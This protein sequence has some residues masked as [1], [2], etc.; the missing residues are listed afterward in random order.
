MRASPNAS[1][2]SNDQSTASADHFGLAQAEAERRLR[3]D[4]YNELPAAS[5]RPFLKIVVDVFLQP[6]FALLIAGGVL[7]AV[8]GDLLE[9]A[10]LG[11]FASLSVLITVTQEMRSERVLEALRDLTSPRALVLRDGVAKRIPGREVAVGDLLLLAEGDRI[12]ADA[13]LDERETLLV[14]ES[15]LTGESLA[16]EK[17]DGS[18]EQAIVHAGTL[19]TRGSARA[20]VIATGRNSEIGKIGQSL[21]LIEMEQPRLQK[22]M[23]AIVRVFGVI[24]AAVTILFILID[25]LLRHRWS[26]AMLGGIALG[27]SMLPEEFPLVMTV[28]TVMGAWRISRVQVLTRKAS[29]IEA[30]GSATVLCT[31]KTGTL[32]QNR[33]SVVSVMAKGRELT[34]SDGEPDEMV[35]ELL[36]VAARASKRDSSDAV[37]L[38]FANYSSPETPIVHFGVSPEWPLMVNIYAREGGKYEIDAKGAPEAIGRLCGM[39]SSALADLHRSLAYPAAKGYRMLAVAESQN[40]SELPR[41]IPELRL[42]FVGLAG[43]ADPLRPEARQAVEECRSAGIRV[44]MVT[45]DYPVT[46]LSVAKEAGI[47]GGLVLSGAELKEMSDEEL[48]ENLTSVNVFARI[49]PDQKLRIVN[50][51]KDRGEVVAMTGDGVNDAPSLKAAHIGIA[52]GGRGTD[53]AREAS[54]IV[55]L[56]DDFASLVRTIK[57]GRRIYDNLRKAVVFIVA[58]H[59]PIAGLTLA[60]FAFGLPLIMTP[61]LIALIEMLIDPACSLVLEAEPEETDVMKR[62]PHDPKVNIVTRPLMLWGVLQGVLALGVVVGVMAAAAWFGLPVNEI[63]SLSFVLL[64]MCNIALILSNRSFS[65]SILRAFRDPNPVLGWGT[66]GI[67]GFFALLLYWP[68][69]AALFGFGPFHGHDLAMCLTGGFALLMLLVALKHFMRREL[70]A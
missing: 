15:L 50:L 42:N 45:G 67:S 57:L 41:S 69:A 54:S 55:L 23:T 56:N 64:L 61:M 3:S 37:D 34:P 28:F 36:R 32:T 10:V 60:P 63:R 25:G 53:V 21:N 6:M 20:V 59:I 12:P 52:M 29:A 58:V 22:Q 2:T 11:V 24:G 51:L 16:V 62:P 17:R 9:A 14:D 49:T 26:E 47:A 39:D 48:R 13:R 30:L 68:P 35:S 33:M 4:G 40:V 38:A 27:M 18:G 8:I 44:I 19:V 65:M 7:Y 1:S 43:L 46:A 70:R 5:S 31:D 66:F